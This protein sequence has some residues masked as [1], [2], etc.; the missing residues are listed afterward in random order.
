MLTTSELI[1]RY[2]NLNNENDID[3]VLDCCADNVL[4][5]SIMNPNNTVRLSGK[6]Q[7]REV[8]EGTLQAFA[9]RKH[10]I[11]SLIV[12]G[13]RAAAETIFKGVAKVEL[14]DGVMP[15]DTISIRGATFFETK[16][17]LIN[18]ICDYS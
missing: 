15:G 18:R 4:F 17:G 13:E 1:E 14:G 16:D 9:D 12:N 8:F 2:I 5:E 6:D 7:V 3:G 10:Q 11:S